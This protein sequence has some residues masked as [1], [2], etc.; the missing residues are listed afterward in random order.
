MESATAA[1]LF[2]LPLLLVSIVLVSVAWLIS[3]AARELDLKR[4]VLVHLPV[5]RVW[6]SVR[7]FPTLHARHGKVRHLG[8][9]DEWVLRRGDGE[10]PGSV[11][12]ALGRWGR[13]PYWAELEIIRAVE[14]RELSISLIRD[15]LGTHRA[16]TA[17]LGSLTLEPVAPGTTKLT[18][19]LRAKVRGPRLRIVRILSLPRLQARLFDQGLR[20]IKVNLEKEAERPAVPVAAGEAAR[21]CVLPGSPSGEAPPLHTGRSPEQS[22]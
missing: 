5:D 21:D 2:L 13:N 19:R 17:H 14:C 6:A 15:S 8:S 20:S 7:H 18:W 4:S 10:S 11:W 9:V 3:A 1:P 12:R 22:L 16:L